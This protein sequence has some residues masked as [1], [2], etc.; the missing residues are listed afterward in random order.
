M[1]RKSISD[2][3]SV[4]ANATNNNV[5]SNTRFENVL[6]F[7][8]V[9]L[10]ATGSATGLFHTLFIGDRNYVERSGVSAQNRTPLVPDDA[11]VTDAEAAPGEKIQLS[12][13]NTTAGALTY[14]FTL[15]FDD[16][17]VASE[18]F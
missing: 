7:G 13:E 4:G 10:L 8:M 6:N 12:V 14:F 17:V 2:S 3:V 16:D 11:V 15:I 18:E 1:A 5:L 9:D